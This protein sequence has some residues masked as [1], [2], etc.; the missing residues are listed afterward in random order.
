MFTMMKRFYLEQRFLNNCTDLP[1]DFI[2]MT[3]FF[4]S[5]WYI[6]RHT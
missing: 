6:Y 5:L 2:D 1:S 4:N 3:I